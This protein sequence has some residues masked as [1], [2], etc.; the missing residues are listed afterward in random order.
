MAHDPRRNEVKWKD[1][2]ILFHLVF[3]SWA[4][5][6]TFSLEQIERYLTIRPILDYTDWTNLHNSTATYTE[7]GYHT[8]TKDDFWGSKEYEESAA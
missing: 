6:E 3:T 2:N 7:I 4:T 5:S 8:C 1:M